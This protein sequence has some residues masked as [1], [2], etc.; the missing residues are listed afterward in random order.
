MIDTYNNPPEEFENECSYC[1][2]PC[3]KR[4][5]DNNCQKAYDSDN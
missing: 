4:F 2:E 5:C 1:G 3:Y